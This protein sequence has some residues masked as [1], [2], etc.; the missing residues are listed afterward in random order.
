MLVQARFLRVI[1]YFLLLVS[2]IYFFILVPS[3]MPMLI[4][5]TPSLAPLKSVVLFAHFF[6]AVPVF[7][8]LYALVDIANHMEDVEGTATMI[9]YMQHALLV[10]AITHACLLLKLRQEDVMQPVIFIV[11]GSSF[12]FLFAFFMSSWQW[13]IQLQKKLAK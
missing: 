6:T 13:R 4:E 10:I 12:F 3:S 11:I 5:M 8:T 2:G 9:R 7:F 1:A